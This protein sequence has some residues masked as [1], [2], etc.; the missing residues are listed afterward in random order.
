MGESRELRRF[1]R[2]LMRV[3]REEHCHRRMRHSIRRA[4]EEYF[5]G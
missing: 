2:H 1:L 5:Y 4:I 3:M